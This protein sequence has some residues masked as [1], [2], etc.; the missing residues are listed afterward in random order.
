MTSLFLAAQAAAQGGGGF[1]GMIF[2]LVAIFVIMYFFMV[3]PQQKRQKK[4]REFQNS[5]SDGSK[6]VTGGGIYGT[7]KRIDQAK[8][9]IDVEVAHGVVITVDKGYVFADATQGQPNA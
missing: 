3:R 9:T 1:G 4:I 6:V 5:L 2:M 7:V 8:N